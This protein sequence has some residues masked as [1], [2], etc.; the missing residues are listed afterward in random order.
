[1]KKTLIVKM[2][3]NQ[4]NFKVLDCLK[5]GHLFIYYCCY[6]YTSPTHTIN[7]KLLKK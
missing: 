4:E 7:K 6:G 1:M 5:V 2:E 3:Y